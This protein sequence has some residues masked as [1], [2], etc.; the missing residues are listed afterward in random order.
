MRYAK[1]WL[2]YA[3][4]TGTEEKMHA[5]VE[6]LSAQ[7]EA[8]PRLRQALQSPVVRA[9]EKLQLLCTAATPSAATPPV[10]DATHSSTGEGLQVTPSEGDAQQ[11][12]PTS[13]NREFT[14]FLTLVMR[15]HREEYLR[16][17]CLTFLHLYRQAHHIGVGRLTTAVPVSAEMAERI[18]SRAA[19]ITHAQQMQ[20]ITAVNPQ[21]VGGFLF[22]IN[23]YRL[24]ASV[25]TQLKRITEQFIDKNRRIV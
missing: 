20:L 16:F 10:H 18:R 13:V 8:S 14:R 7:L 2:A 6:Q 12:Q 25:A 15:N 19:A 24:D 17:I 23:H 4:Q 11:V 5:L 1:A 9:E 22:D 21:I 3:K